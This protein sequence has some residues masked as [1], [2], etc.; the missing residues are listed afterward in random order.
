MPRQTRQRASQPLVG[1]FALGPLAHALD[2]PPAEFGVLHADRMA[3][4]AAIAARALPVRTRFQGGRRREL[5]LQ[6][7]T[8]TSSPFCSS[9]TSGAI[10]PLIL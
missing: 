9:D 6:V 2:D 7:S 5:G 4:R 1:V 8:S 3:R 10:L